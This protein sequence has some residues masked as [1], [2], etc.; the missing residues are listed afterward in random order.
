MELMNTWKSKISPVLI[1]GITSLFRKCSEF[2]ILAT[3]MTLVFGYVF[4]L[5]YV[6]EGN[7]CMSLYSLVCSLI[8][9]TINKMM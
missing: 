1:K 3:F 8:A 7:Y 4:F 9:T 2:I 5:Y 6:Y